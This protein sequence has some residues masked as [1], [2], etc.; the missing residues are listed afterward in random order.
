VYAHR[1]KTGEFIWDSGSWGQWIGGT[2]SKGGRNAKFTDGSHIIGQ[3][4]SLNGCLVHMVCTNT[5]MPVRNKSVKNTHGDHNKIDHVCYTM[6]HV[7]CDHSTGWTPLHNLH[8]HSKHTH[9]FLSHICPCHTA[10]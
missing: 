7:R 9:K 6:P 3:A 4:I 10:S 1:G 5:T 2:E 8:V